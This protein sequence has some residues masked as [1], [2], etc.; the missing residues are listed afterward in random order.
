MGSFGLQ[1]CKQECLP[2]PIEAH[3]PLSPQVITLSWSVLLSFGLE[4]V[5]PH[6][7]HNKVT[8]L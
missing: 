8:Y 7:S 3:A 6:S 1:K 4:H 5:G 2:N